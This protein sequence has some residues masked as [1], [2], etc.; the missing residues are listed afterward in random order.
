MAFLRKVYGLFLLGLGIAGV[1]GYVG[2]NAIDVISANWLVLIIGYFATFFVCQW[3]RRSFPVNIALFGL[4]TFISGLFWGPILAFYLLGG[5]AGV[6]VQA[7]GITCCIFTGLTVYTLTSKA[8]FSYLGGALSIGIF[9]LLGL[10]IFGMFF[11]ISSGMDFA[12]SI[13]AVVLFS[14]F[15]L[16]DTSNILHHYRTDEYV[17]GAL[18]LYLDFV[19]LLRYILALLSRRD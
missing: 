6:L 11:P 4:F 8:D 17:A 10:I 12:I 13:G 5:Q 18:A 9:A 19:L 1:G 14:G 15:V 7:L 3:Q 16:Y 2:M